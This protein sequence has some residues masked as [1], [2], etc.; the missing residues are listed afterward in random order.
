MRS[1]LLAPEAPLPARSGLPLRIVN[2]ARALAEEVDLEIAALADPP[3]PASAERFGVTHFPGEWDRRVAVARAAWEPWPVAQMRS[4]ALARYVREAD[5]DVLQ[6]HSLPM[7]RYL[8]ASRPSVFDT[9]DTMTSVT[10]M[11]ANTD[12]RAAM[13]LLWRYEAI[14]TRSY[15]SRAAR[16]A[17]TV[18]VPTDAD[19]EL[20]ERL[21]AQRIV[22]VPNGIDL[23]ANPHQLPASGAE[24]IFVGYFAWR[25]NV[26]AA[27]ELCDAIFPR[28]RARVPGAQLTLVGAAAP[29]ELQTRAGPA[30]EVTGGVD[31]VLVYL[32]RARV[33][34]MPLRAGG[35]SRLKVLEALAAGIPVV[36]TP[37]AVTGITVRAGVHALLG[38]SAADLAALATRVIED[39]D[40]AASLSRSGRELVQ[41]RYGWPTVAAP[42]VG[43]HRELA[44]RYARR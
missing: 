17:T 39:D 19:A 4:R 22:I 41:Q 29:P 11:M 30:I 20:F 15:E 2:L 18:T 28:L 24:V 14:K 10:R 32:R 40:L 3:A 26:E 36:A 35:G 16:R 34:V 5:W 25:P 1:L 9:H 33:T 7:T 43:L 27:L 31:D 12:S 37:F 38:E 44:E 23:D 8:P 13:R 21:G 6:T 42:L